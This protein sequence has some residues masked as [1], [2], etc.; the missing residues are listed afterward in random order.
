MLAKEKPKE[1]IESGELE[2]GAGEAWEWG[3]ARL[4]EGQGRAEAQDSV[5]ALLGQHLLSGRLRYN[6]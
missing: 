6:P 3:G 1:K 5:M 2:I 4:A